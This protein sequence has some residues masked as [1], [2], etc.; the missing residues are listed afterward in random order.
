MRVLYNP[1]MLAP[2]LTTK[3]FMPPPR[4]RAVF[5]ERLIERLNGNEGRVRTLTLVSAPAG[6]GKST[7]LGAWIDRLVR[8]DPCF[9]VAWIT[10]D[11]GDNDPSRFLLYLASALHGVEPSCGT[12]AMAALRSPQ[13]PSAKSILTDLINEIDGIRCD[14]LLVLDDYHAVRSPQVDEALAFLLEHLPARLRLVIATREDPSLPLSRLRARGELTELRADDL[15][16]S[17]DEAADFLGRVMGLE[18]KTQDIA[19]LE[20]RTEGWIAGLQLAALSMQ[21]QKDIAAFIRSF[22]GSHRFVLDYLV[23]EVLRHQ[24]AGIHVFLLR[25]SM[26]DRLCGPLCDALMRED[27]GS[28][29]EDVASGQETLE[30]L[31]RTNLFIVPLDGERGWYRYH[32]LFAELLRQRFEQSLAADSS[33]GGT[34]A[35]ALQIRASLWYEENGLP[36]EAF[37]HAAAAAD[38]DRAERLANSG[39]MPSH[40][41]GAVIA[42]L[43]WLATLPAGVLDAR[44]TLRVLTATM[45]LVAGRTAGVEEA[46]QAA[47]LALQGAEPDETTRDLTGRI[48]AARATLALTRYQPEE[49]LVQSHRAL[50]HLHPDNLPFRLTAMWTTA[51]AHFLNGDRESAGQTFIELERFSQVGG[52]AFFTQMALC[53]LGMIQESDSKLHEAAQ[54]YRRALISFG[55]NPQPNANEAYLGLARISYEWNDLDAAEEYGERGLQLARQYDRSI[56]RFILGELVLARITLARGQVAAA[57]ARL[58]ALA[59]TSRTPSFRHRL[60]EIAAL[61][62]PVLLR[63]GCIEAAASLAET[64]NLPQGRARVFLARGEPSSALALLEPL[65]T[66]LEARGWQD[67]RLR[68]LTLQALALH[69]EGREDDAL[70]VLSETMGP[71]EGGGIM[72]LFLD[73]GAPMAG[74]LAMAAARGIMPVYAGRLIAAF[75]AEKREGPLVESNPSLSPRLL[76]PLSRRELE[77][78]RLLAEGLSNQE[79]GERLF[80]ALDTVKG[81]N[82]RIFDKLEVRRRTE[83]IARGRELGLL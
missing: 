28:R 40:F 59:I 2:I 46:L 77:V 49:I 15:R 73:E 47:E 34:T 63:Q 4:A 57:A 79:I 69:A 61:Q 44:P 21:G 37:R 19:V 64:F 74:L 36:I 71:A 67:E 12:D 11:E 52:D 42:I 13:P 75:T 26:L 50:E 78:L 9:H 20:S 56:D 68:V 53:G 45:S 33:G 31:E 18:L 24:P 16:F 54:T 7:L 43:D 17:T 10:L 81:H 23:E 3:L 27:P 51:F 8:Q 80:L 1:R 83:A 55:D 65:R 30:Y 29:L 35:A 38:I 48:A 62:V 70:R 32:R 72:R 58:D 39:G 82:R 22:S 14:I 6:F 41:R 25:T 76:E 60:P 66:Q 5:R